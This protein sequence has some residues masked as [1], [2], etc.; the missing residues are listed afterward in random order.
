MNF[1]R[2]QR[3]SLLTAK[4][5]TIAMVLVN[6]TG[7]VLVQQK[8]KGAQVEDP[9]SLD[10]G[11]RPVTFAHVD[12]PERLELPK[13]ALSIND[14][15]TPAAELPMAG[16]LPALD[17]D[18]AD[19]LPEVAPRQARKQAPRPVLDLAEFVPDPLPVAQSRPSAASRQT[20]VSEPSVRE[21]AP[22]ELKLTQIDR[23]PEP[24]S[25]RPALTV[26]PARKPI[27]SEAPAAKKAVV[28]A[29]PVASKLA[30]AEAPKPQRMVLA[31]TAPLRAVSLEAPTAK[32]S[33]TADAATP[34]RPALIE[35][36]APLPN[37]A[38]LSAPTNGLDSYSA[39]FVQSNGDAS[40]ARPTA[41]FVAPDV[42]ELPAVAASPTSPNPPIATPASEAS[43]DQELSAAAFDAPMVS[44]LPNFAPI[45]PVAQPVPASAT[46]A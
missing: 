32:H 16:S 31:D 5:F 38:A 11:V 46:S 13:I 2:A 7:Y 21:E 41:T 14:V 8:M 39:A 20:A 17:L 44:E 4:N 18:I 28:A 19:A 3:T 34:R 1:S 6:A 23:M 42:S 37:V 26:P 35:A 45:V 27:V 40:S 24:Q 10:D 22:L 25:A 36:P 29:A 33:A 12:L 30:V 43:V 9:Y 15:D